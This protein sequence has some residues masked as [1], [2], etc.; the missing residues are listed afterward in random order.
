MSR[1]TSLWFSSFISHRRAPWL[2]VAA[3]P[4]FSRF[5]ECALKGNRRSFLLKD[6]LTIITPVD[7]VVAS[8]NKFH[9]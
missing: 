1:P 6:S 3:C 7:H 5:I 9:A 8:T 4:I 2:A